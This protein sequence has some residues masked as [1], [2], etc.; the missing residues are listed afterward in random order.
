[1]DGVMQPLAKKKPQWMQDLFFTVKLAQQKL[2][3]YY[4]ELTPTGM[5]VISTHMLHCFCKFRLT[6]EQEK[7]MNVN[8]DD[9]TSYSTQYPEAFLKYVEN[10]NCAIY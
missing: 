7:G 4:G 3:K 8:S 10:K 1:M 9:K 5:I 2:S 6:R